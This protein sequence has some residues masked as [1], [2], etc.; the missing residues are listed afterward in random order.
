[1]QINRRSFLTRGAMAGAGIATVSRHQLPASQVKEMAAIRPLTTVTVPPPSGDTTGATDTPAL[2]AALASLSPREAIILTQPGYYIN[3]PL[4]VPSGCGITAPVGYGVGST[5]HIKAAAGFSGPAMIANAGFLKGLSYGEDGLEISNLFI[6]GSNG[7]PPGPF[8]STHGHGIVLSASHCHVHHNFVYNVSGSGIV[9]ADFNSKGKPITHVGSTEENY[10][11]DNK[12]ENPGQFCIWVPKTG[13]SIGMTDGVIARN[14]LMDPSFNAYYRGGFGNPRISPT[15]NLPFEAVRVDDGGGWWVEDNHAYYCPGGAYA[16]ASMFGTHILNNTC[17]MFGSFPWSVVGG[18][19]TPA[20]IIGLAM[21][22]IKCSY[23]SGAGFQGYQHPNG[24]I[25]NLM[26]AFEGL[27]NAGPTAM[28]SGTPNAGC[29]IHYYDAIVDTIAVP[30][31]ATGE[32]AVVF[33]GNLANQNSSGGQSAAS[34]TT[35]SGSST[36]TAP[37]GAFATIQRGMSVVGAG[38]PAG[39]YVGTVSSGSSDSLIL[40]AGDLVTLVNATASGTATLSFPG[41]YSLAE[42]WSSSTPGSALNVQ[43]VAN[44]ALGTIIDA[45]TVLTSGGASI[46][47]IAE[48]AGV[49]ISGGPPSPGQVLVAESA[50]GAAWSGARGVVKQ[51][52]SPTPGTGGVL[53]TPVAVTL[54]AG[55][56]GVDLLAFQWVPNGAAGETLTLTITAT[57]DNGASQS[58]S[59]TAVGSAATQSGAGDQIVGL[60]LNGHFVTGLTVACASSAPTTTA[61]PA[62][63]VVCLPIP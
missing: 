29:R 32:A 41:P 55:I 56:A 53:G 20:V 22:G 5:P 35:Q 4:S 14:I 34:C 31:G 6:D 26:N 30:P 36:V 40:V 54:P 18:K 12:I 58:V 63:T 39:T 10:I 60:A 38:I 48:V 23:N 15:T 25:G 33:M 3:A 11:Y 43:H 57:Y 50:T 59:P 13:G 8:V 28:G 45:P 51:L 42:S 7:G 27:N 24:V 49:G 37:G 46:T 62:V 44:H 9:A 52:L 1:M 19:L 16:F 61:A 17:D 47:L 21:H 2:N